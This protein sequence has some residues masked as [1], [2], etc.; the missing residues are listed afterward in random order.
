MTPECPNIL[1]ICTDQQR[2]DTVHALGNSAIRTPSLDRL[3]AQGVVFTQ[4]FCQ[5]PACTPSRTSFLTGLYPSSVHGNIIGNAHCNLPEN[6]RLVTAR[7]RDAG[8]DCGLAGKLHLASA[9]EGEEI[10]V[11]DGYRRFWYSHSGT[12][13]RNDE[14][15]YWSWLRSIGRFDEVLDTSNHRPELQAGVRYRKNFDP[16]LHQTAWCCDRAIDFMNERRDGP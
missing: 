8:Y 15:Q 4:A 1:W 13:N 7:L 9:W 5:N 6:A 16:E 10:R 2:Y 14:N 12:Q 3:C 11:D